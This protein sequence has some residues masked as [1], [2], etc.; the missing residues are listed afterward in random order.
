MKTHCSAQKEV[1]FE[2]Q[3]QVLMFAEQFTTIHFYYQQPFPRWR[4][5]NSLPHENVEA[6][7]DCSVLASTGLRANTIVLIEEKIIVQQNVKCFNP[8]QPY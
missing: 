7:L 4:P 2:K 1:K 3:F 8:L 5:I 6:F